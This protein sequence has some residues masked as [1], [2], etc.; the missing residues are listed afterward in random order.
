MLNLKFVVQ[1]TTMCYNI[2]NTKR[3]AQILEGTYN[4]KFDYPAAYQPYYHFNAIADVYSEKLEKQNL[5]IITQEN[6]NKIDF[7]SWGLMPSDWVGTRKQW[8]DRN[9]TFNS[10]SER[11][12]QSDLYSKHIFENRCLIIA[13][14]MFESHEV[15]GHKRKIPHYFK[16]K[17]HDLFAFAGIYSVND[18][19]SETPSITASIITREALPFWKEIHNKTNEDDQYRMPTVL[20]PSNYQDW[21]N[22]NLSKT[23]IEILARDFTKQEIEVYPVSKDVNSNVD[24]NRADIIQRVNH[25][26]LNQQLDLFG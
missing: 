3:K 18:N 22:P 25:S 20:D 11:L 9:F 19:V 15:V 14:G 26:E 17:N 2:S 6:P 7:A 8:A 4:A 13:D 1:S 5:Y 12:F 10:K 16:T 21:L 24:S 23:D